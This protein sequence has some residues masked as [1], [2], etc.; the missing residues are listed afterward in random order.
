MAKANET[1]RRLPAACMHAGSPQHVCM[2]AARY[3]YACMHAGSGYCSSVCYVI[4]VGNARSLPLSGTTER[5][6]TQAA[7]GHTGKH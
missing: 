5:W 4:F 7:F 6:F 3:M 1:T 2:Q